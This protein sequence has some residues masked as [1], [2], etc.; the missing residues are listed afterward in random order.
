MLNVSIKKLPDNSYKI[1]SSDDKKQALPWKPNSCSYIKLSLSPENGVINPVVLW[2]TSLTSANSATNASNLGYGEHAIQ[3]LTAPSMTVSVFADKIDAKKYEL[4]QGLARVDTY[5]EI[6][7]KIRLYK[8]DATSEKD[9]IKTDATT[10]LKELPKMDYDAMHKKLSRSAKLLKALGENEFQA[11]FADEINPILDLITKLLLENKLK[12]SDS[13]VLESNYS[14]KLT[15]ELNDTA[16]ALRNVLNEY[17]KLMP[18][19]QQTFEFDSNGKPKGDISKSGI[20]LGKNVSIGRNVKIGFGAKIGEG[21]RI[22]DYVEIAPFAEIGKRVN[23]G[24]GVKVGK[25]FMYGSGAEARLS[26]FPTIIKDGCHINGANIDSSTV[27]GKNFNIYL[28]DNLD[29]AITDSTNIQ[30][31]GSQQNYQGFIPDNYDFESY[32]THGY[33]DTDIASLNNK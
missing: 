3:K 25:G 1:T 32:S 4:S 12:F 8:S 20:H 17:M 31:K 5:V 18:I 11:E 16:K 21:T 15:P 9:K 33:G 6:D 10:T 7:G 29:N 23:I 30:M 24:R 27:I 22:D 2:D 13:I 14:R 28:S 26:G 19:Q